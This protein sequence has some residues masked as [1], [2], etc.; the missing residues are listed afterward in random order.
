MTDE[1]RLRIR[2]VV[3]TIVSGMIDSTIED[4]SDN[5]FRERVIDNISEEDYDEETHEMI[6]NDSPEE[7]G[8][9]M[10]I[11]YKLVDQITDQYMGR[12]K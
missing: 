5:Y 4:I 8:I 12:F 11:Y 6:H 7:D 10:E 9:D 2:E 1:K 3:K